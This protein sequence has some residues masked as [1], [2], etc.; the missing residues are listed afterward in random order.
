MARRGRPAV[1]VT[2]TGDER[3]TLQRWAKRHSS[4]QSLALRCKIVL[5]CAEGTGTHTEIAAALGCSDHGRQVAEPV[6]HR[7]PRRA[8]RCSPSGR[9]PHDR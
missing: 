5:A 2:L 4:A 6:R 1:E 7:S 8:R 3:K 9:G